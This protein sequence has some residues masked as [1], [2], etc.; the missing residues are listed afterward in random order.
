MLFQQIASILPLLPA[1]DDLAE[2]LVAEEGT[3]VLERMLRAKA[4]GDQ[5]CIGVAAKFDEIRFLNSFSHIS[6]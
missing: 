4:R 6:A 3:P 1:E 5:E 2:M